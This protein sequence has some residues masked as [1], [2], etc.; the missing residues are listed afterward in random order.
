MQHYIICK[1]LEKHQ[2]LSK[3]F[4]DSHK[5]IE[6]SKVISMRN[7]LI[8]DYFGV[9]V[10]LVWKVVEND[11]PNLKIKVTKIMKIIPLNFH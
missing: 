2:D 10:K 3:E 4:K 8:H 11:I 9:E 7:K 5:D 1:L 6:W